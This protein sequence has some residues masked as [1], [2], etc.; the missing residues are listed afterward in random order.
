MSI[1]KLKTIND[2]NGSLTVVNETSPNLFPIKRIFFIYNVPINITRGKH[3]HKNTK[4][5]L[6]C[7]SGS[8]KVSLDD[9]KNYK[10]TYELN[11]PSKGIFQ[12][13]LIWGE[14]FDFRENTVLLVLASEHYDEKD[15]I[16][17]YEEFKTYVS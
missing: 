15:Y 3:C 5:Y 1:D 13:N 11:S 10:E 7:L 2:F 12:N 9:G 17:N 4:Q 14:L 6:I 16:K 8:C